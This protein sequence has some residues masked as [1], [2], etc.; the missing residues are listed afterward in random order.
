M[1]INAVAN[2]RQALRALT[3]MGYQSSEKPNRNGFKISFWGLRYSQV[4]REP[5]LVSYSQRV[6]SV[7]QPYL[8]GSS[9][10]GFAGFFPVVGFALLAFNA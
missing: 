10:L 4:L 3:F 9:V 5:T 2:P 8:S 7:S 1:K 6:L